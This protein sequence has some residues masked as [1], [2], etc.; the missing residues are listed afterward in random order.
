MPSSPGD[1]RYAL[2]IAVDTY[3]D[4]LLHD[5]RAPLRDAAALEEVFRDPAIG[6]FTEVTVLRNP[7][8][9]TA[10]ETVE[11]FFARS[12]AA[13]VVVF[14][15]SGHAFRGEKTDEL[16]LALTDTDKTKA[17]YTTSIPGTALREL[18]EKGRAN[19]KLL[20]LDC[21]HGGALTLTRGE[22]QEFF[23]GVRGLVPQ[24]MGPPSPAKGT[25][26]IGAARAG[27]LA[28]EAE[29]GALSG[30]V[31]EGLKTGKADYGRLGKVSTD[32]LFRYVT[33]WC[34]ENRPEQHPVRQELAHSGAFIVADNPFCTPVLLPDKVKELLGSTEPHDRLD[35]L[36]VL[37]D[38]ACAEHLELAEMARSQL[39]L[40]AAF[41][42][43][44][45]VKELAASLLTHTSLTVVS[46]VEFGKVRI[47]ELSAKVVKVV[48]PP[49]AG[50]W[51]AHSDHPAVAAVRHRDNLEIRLQP[52]HGR[53]V[54]AKVTVSSDAGDAVV[55]VSAQ[56]QRQLPT[57]KP[58]PALK[59]LPTLKMPRYPGAG[60]H[61]WLAAVAAATILLTATSLHFVPRAQVIGWCIPRQDLRVLTT[62]ML[63]EPVEAAAA[64]FAASRLADD[65]AQTQV[66]VSTTPSDGQAQ[67]RIARQWP[68]AELRT[69]GPSPDVWLPESSMQVDRARQAIRPDAP[70]RL[71]LPDAAATRA[72]SVASSPL[73]FAVPGATGPS[74]LSWA[75]LLRGAWTIPRA[76][77]RRSST[78]LLV[79][80]S[81]YEAAK[82][83][84]SAEKILKP[85]QGG[86]DSRYDLCQQRLAAEPPP[87]GTGY[88]VPAKSVHDYNAGNPLG[89][90]CQVN[91]A[92]P[93]NRQLRQVTLSAAPVLDVPCVP[94]GDSAWGDDQQRRLADEFCRYLRGP[95]RPM[96]LKHGLDPPK[97]DAAEALPDA[98]AA[99][100]V[101]NTWSAAQRPVRM[102]LAMDVSG[103]MRL[104]VPGSSIQRIK[105]TTAAARKA[106]AESSFG[107]DDQTG[108]WEFATKLSGARDYRE[109]APL[110]AATSDHQSLLADKLNGLKVSNRNT[111]LNDTISAGIEA[112]RKGTS[113]DAEFA[114]VN[115]LVV[116]TD[117]ENDDPGSI[118]VDQIGR[119]LRGSG[120]QVSVI[121]SVGANCRA[122]E[123]LRRQGLSCFDETRGG[124][125]AAFDQALP[126]R[127]AKSS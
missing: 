50:D 76:D 12:A 80:S 70:H 121:A 21:C 117:G 38:L 33:Q 42:S 34:A 37:R 61:P 15:F 64:G 57:L 77:P 104:P 115:L 7:T 58:L 81:L 90:T 44:W 89:D 88:V 53:H 86:D 67:E 9:K 109:L 111:G 65:C 125:A 51:Q 13:D 22:D 97:P 54:R 17:P 106:V 99:E 123:P 5:L 62:E 126:S 122:F 105:A 27:E 78:G 3:A 18:L 66:T 124:L 48:G 69:A 84:H 45:R 119:Q 68:D 116:L 73:V 29:N 26:I 46:R 35:A 82:D 98:N 11:S 74:S 56:V 55:E 101:I 75:A 1:A 108:L 95:G 92:P 32:D 19:R 110:A 14:H 36:N 94:I 63:R 31:V 39:R 4:D 40:V 52:R 30:A 83:P 120:V 93:A 49:L 87:A 91:H 118:G 85:S 8:A 79:T 16:Y 96:L 71:E 43:D 25:I 10:M 72:A 6:R 102:L 24:V 20:L 107:D 2:I 41:D 23:R 28:H 60:T 127:A 113:P 103:S 100:Q 114:P 59:L 112:L 47:G